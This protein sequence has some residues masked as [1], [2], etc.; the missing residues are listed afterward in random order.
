MR[1]A[2]LLICLAITLPLAATSCNPQSRPSECSTEADCGSDQV[3][4]DGACVPVTCKSDQDCPAGQ[5]CEFVGEYCGSTCFEQWPPP[6]G[7][8]NF[9]DI[10]AGV[11]AFQKVPGT[12]WPDTTWVDLHGN[13]FGDA[14][15]ESRST[16]HIGTGQPADCRSRMPHPRSVGWS[17]PPARAVD[18]GLQPYA[19]ADRSVTASPAQTG[20]ARRA[21]SV[22]PCRPRETVRNPPQR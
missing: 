7:F 17:P 20:R 16:P 6:D 19:I 22:A 10:G 2:K 18:A 4:R 5:T 14:T 1:I 3:C 13:D 15:V 12:V 11:K 8:I 9:E 21:V